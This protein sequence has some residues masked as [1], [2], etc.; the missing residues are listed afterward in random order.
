VPNGRHDGGFSVEEPEGPRWKVALELLAEG[1]YISCMGLI[2]TFAKETP[3]ESGEPGS[4]LKVRF[5]TGHEWTTMTAEQAAADIENAEAGVS[6]ICERSPEFARLIA[7][8]PIRYELFD[9]YG[10]V[11]LASKDPSGFR[12]QK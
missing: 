3:R 12:L 10:E 11:L 8:R 2:F 6:E 7:G 9:R 4:T 5:E 1:K